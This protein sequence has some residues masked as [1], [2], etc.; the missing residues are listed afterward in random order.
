MKYPG[1][2][3]IGCEK[4]AGMYGVNEGI[5]DGKGTGVRHLFYDGF[6][7]DLVHSAVTLIKDGDRI[8]YGNRMEKKAGHPVHGRPLD[9]YVEKGFCFSDTFEYEQLRKTDKAFGFGESSL[10]FSVDIE[11]RLHIGRDIEVFA[12]VL[13]RPQKNM[14]ASR[15]GDQVVAGGQHSQV[16]IR[17]E[18][19]DK[20]FIVEEG[21]TGFIYRLTSAVLYD[22][23]FEGPV[24]PLDT[25]LTGVLLGKK[26][27]LPA[28]GHV[29][30]QWT[31]D[32]ERSEE[33]LHQRTQSYPVGQAK[34]LATAYW[35]GYLEAGHPAAHQTYGAQERINR[36]AI[37]SAMI[38]GF[39]PADLTGEL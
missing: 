34:D 5:I 10:G 26:I 17:C 4:L 22:E 6:D 2:S 27:H 13:L 39:V 37:K 19:P 38:G 11:N 20:H 12:Y 15:Q 1:L 9:S 33:A 36:I 14:E 7:L 21:P 35:T 18:D 25:S 16:S 30:F 31:M 32:F 24:R 23:A 8:Y 29:A 28:D 3:I